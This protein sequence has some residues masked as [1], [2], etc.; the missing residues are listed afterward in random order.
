VPSEIDPYVVEYNKDL[1]DASGVDYPGLDWSSDD[2]LRVATALTQGE[3]ES[4]QYGFVGQHYEGREL[5][6]MLGLLGADLINE[7]EDP[8][9]LSFAD[10]TVVEALRWYADLSTL[11]GVKPVFVTD[12]SEATEAA[13]WDREALIDDGR[14]A[15]WTHLGRTNFAGSQ[16][17]FDVGVLPLPSWAGVASAGNWTTAIGYYIS[18][19]QG[20]P[21][22]SDARQACWEWITFLTE[23]PTILQGFPARRS[24]AESAAFDQRVGAERA[25]A[26]RVSV[27][28]AEQPS[29]YQTL[30][31]SGGWAVLTVYWLSQAYGQVLE[32]EL[33]VEQALEAAQELA[34]DYRACIVA[35]DAF[36]D[37][38]ECQACLLETDPTLPDFLF[39]SGE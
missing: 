33:S 15:M 3:G 13:F 10:Q 24:V 16:R 37:Q 17:P 27:A 7:H 1:F 29:L 39:Q 36:Y 30:S 35:R 38:V 21:A 20:Q 34:D 9:A 11:H 2:F 25:A 14:A 5:M 31:E 28:A 32:G 18:A 4:K 22:D 8:F 19:R 23:T 12:I 26:Y 6:T